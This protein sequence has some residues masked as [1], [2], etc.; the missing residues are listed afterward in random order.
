MGIILS[1][2]RLPIRNPGAAPWARRGQRRQL[3]GEWGTVPWKEPA[4]RG[5]IQISFSN[6][7]CIPVMPVNKMLPALG[8]ASGSVGDAGT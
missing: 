2:G 6:M 8:I 1:E 7:Y 4:D 3:A 5:T